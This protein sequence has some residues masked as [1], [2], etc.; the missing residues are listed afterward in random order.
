MQEVRILGISGSP[1][2]G[3]NT[4]ILVKKALEGVL[5]VSGVETEF[6]EMA[7]K[8]IRHCIGCNKCIDKG[9]CVFKDDF[10]DFVKRWMES[11]GIIWG[12]PVYLMGLPSLM[13]AAMERL[14][15]STRHYWD[16]LG[17]AKPRYNKVCGVVAVGNSCYG[18]QELV[19]IYLISRSLAMNCLVVSGNTKIGSSFYPGTGSYIGAPA[20]VQGPE[21][22]AVLRDEGGIARALNVGRR[23]AETTK[24]VRAGTSAL[25]KEL[26]S[27]Y[28]YTY[29]A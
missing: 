28:F 8:K 5:T 7:G 16:K 2:K 20:W 6:Y 1:R 27:E 23:V 14:S 24:I 4:A 19:L 22:D 9:V 13:N 18:G 11:D 29:G 10:Q 17:L 15:N 12:A 26:P 25:K 21:N 3:A